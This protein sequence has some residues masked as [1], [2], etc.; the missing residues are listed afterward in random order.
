MQP[1]GGA[2]ASSRRPARGA[3]QVLCWSERADRAGLSQGINGAVARLR[4]AASRHG[5]A[6][7]GSGPARR[8]WRGPTLTGSATASSA[9]GRRRRRADNR[10]P[11]SAVWCIPLTRPHART[12]KAVALAAIS[13]GAGWPALGGHVCRPDHPIAQG[14]DRLFIVHRR[15]AGRSTSSAGRPGVHLLVR[16]GGVPL[17]AGGTPARV[18][19]STSAGH[20][21]SRLLS[22]RIK[23]IMANAV[24]GRTL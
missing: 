24:V 21:A 1:P 18:G 4:P 2:P 3:H 13:A 19:S 10:H 22:A 9:G 20:R 12:L 6:W 17:S 11:T 15:C 8:N 5:R 23:T 14:L 7:A 16:P